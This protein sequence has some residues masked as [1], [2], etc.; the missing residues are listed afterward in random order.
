MRIVLYIFVID[1]GQNIMR[2]IVISLIF[3]FFILISI[4]GITAL[5]L[6]KNTNIDFDPFM[7]LEVTVK[8]IKIR[9]LEKDDP[10]VFSKEIIDEYS[11]PDFYIKIKIN[12]KEFIS[13]VW[14]NT[15][16][17]YFPEFSVALN[18]PDDVETLDIVIQLWDKADNGDTQD[19]LCDISPDSGTNDDAYDVE[20]TYYISK[21]NWI[22]DDFIGDNSGY[23]RLNGCDDGSYYEPDRDCELWFEIYQ[24]DCDGDCIPYWTEVNVLGIDPTMDDTFLDPDEDKIPTYWEW[25]W[26][27]NPTSWDNHST[28]DTE[29]DGIDNY[30]EFLTSQ[31]FSDPFRRD[32]FVELDQMQD[33]QNGETARLPEISKEILHT[34]YNR[35]NLVYHLDD[36]S[37]GEGSGADLIPFDELTECSWGR[38]TDELDQIYLDYFIKNSEDSWKRSV[39]HYGVV[40]YQSSLVS[41]N[42]FGSNRYQ[43]SAKGMEEK[44]A[45][46][47]WLQRDIVYASAY[48]HEMGHTLNFLPIP[49]HNG[50]SY[51]PWQIGWWASRPYKSCMNYGYMYYT[52][53]YSDGSRPFGDYND[54]ER[55]DLT[56]FQRTDW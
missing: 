24:N 44:T 26:G 15:K 20:L 51:Y 45:Q 48:M 4:L 21:G 25:K 41:G 18:V 37:W 22:D 38:E 5:S 47:P 36:G 56:Y 53:D 19:R 33:G 7:D 13:P 23:G 42:M 35:H 1:R 31:W 39:F 10:Q 2:K 34:A 55:M 40:I 29:N 54:W 50:L 6:N 16:Y 27:Y 8:I 11:D 17:I 46:F 32:L 9:S 43:I 49:G 3:A 30:E 52:V 28:I 12:E 14:E